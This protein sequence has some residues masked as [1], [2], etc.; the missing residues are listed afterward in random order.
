MASE[1]SS[2]TA[3]ILFN[4][5]VML[6]IEAPELYSRI[7]G[8]KSLVTQKLMTEKGRSPAHNF[9]DSYHDSVLQVLR[10]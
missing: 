10:E 3:Q 2:L 7:E 4:V 6:K 1:K 5:V 8:V 9:T